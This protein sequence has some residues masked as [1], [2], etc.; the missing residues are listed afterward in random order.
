MGG[1]GLVLCIV[2]G[3][4]D[5][6]ACALGLLQQDPPRQ[7]LN[8]DAVLQDGCQVGVVRQQAR[9]DPLARAAVLHGLQA[10]A[11]VLLEQV[12]DR[13]VQQAQEAH[14]QSGMGQSGKLACA[15]L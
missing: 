8:L 3:V 9:Q 2:E 11:F 14:H 1:H 15:G 12:P 6:S 5:V 4:A 10:P 13:T 7:Q